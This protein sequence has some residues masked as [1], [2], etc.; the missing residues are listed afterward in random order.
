MALSENQRRANEKLETKGDKHFERGNVLKALRYYARA[1]LRE[2]VLAITQNIA[3]DFHNMNSFP[4]LQTGIGRDIISALKAVLATDEL[5][6]F[7][8]RSWDAHERQ[9]EIALEAFE[10]CDDDAALRERSMTLLEENNLPL[11]LRGLR[12]YRKIRMRTGTNAS[13]KD[14]SL[15]ECIQHNCAKPIA[16]LSEQT[17]TLNEAEEEEL[18]SVLGLLEIAGDCNGLM[19]LGTKL[20][21]KK[22][23]LW[24]IDAYGRALSVAQKQKITMSDAILMRLGKLFDNYGKRGLSFMAYEMC[25][26]T[27]ELEQQVTK[28]L[29]SGNLKKAFELLP[30]LVHKNPDVLERLKPQLNNLIRSLEMQAHA[31]RGK[32]KK[33]KAERYTEM[34]ALLQKLFPDE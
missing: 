28:L 12:M 22:Q 7:A 23:G 34:A 10:A 15:T 13:D 33:A 26:A 29:S 5:R 3:G 18:D 27:D 17:K 25:G 4:R 19:E 24:H 30:L 6:L 2:K 14:E 32:K 16:R 20:E 21:E 11:G 31:A 9:S 8:A 1:Q